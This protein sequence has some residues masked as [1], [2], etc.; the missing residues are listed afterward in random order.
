MIF[1]LQI[2]KTSINFYLHLI[3]KKKTVRY[4]PFEVYELYFNEL[5]SIHFKLVGE[6]LEF[7]KKEK[8]S[9][10]IS[11]DQWMLV[12]DLLKCIGDQFPKGY[13]IDEAWPSLF[14]EFYVWY[15]KKYDI[16]IEMPEY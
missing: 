7:M 12:L 4:I 13:N 6:F 10:K 16:K 2:S 3:L 8:E 1:T 11:E 14:D 9:C 15:C 5:F